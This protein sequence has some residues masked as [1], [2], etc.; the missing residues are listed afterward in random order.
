MRFVSSWIVF[1][2]PTLG[3]LGCVEEEERPDLI[4]VCS[5]DCKPGVQSG[6]SG[7]STPSAT[8]SSST[9]GGGDEVVL[10]GDLAVF[11]DDRFD[12]G[13]VVPF[14]ESAMVFSRDAFSRVLDA[15]YDGRSFSITGLEA[16]EATGVLSV[17][18]D[19]N[20]FAWPTLLRVNTLE[21]QSITLPLV[22][23]EVLSEIYSS[24]RSQAL[25]E[26]SRGQLVLRFSDADL[27]PIAGVRV[28]V[29]QAAFVAYKEGA[30]WSEDATETDGSGLVVAGNI[31][32]S[33]FPG[34]SLNVTASGAA[35]GSWVVTVIA[36]AASYDA[37]LAL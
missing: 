29:P 27:D 35:V 3:A 6:G 10:E 19:P 22:N 23:S 24:I 15:T 11:V 21:S 34:S 33:D 37:L 30:G 8:S 25:V 13:S 12:P 9:T 2:A 31:I 36:G 18:D 1:L 17:P 32:A 16:G 14:T 26:P 7:P 4:S 5:D 28:D 20:S